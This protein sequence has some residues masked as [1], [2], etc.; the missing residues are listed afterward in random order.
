M[1][2]GMKSV[3]RCLWVL[4]VI[5]GFAATDAR[6][7]NSYSIGIEGFRDSYKEY[8][9]DAVA[10]VDPHVDVHTD[11]G[12]VTANYQ[13]SANGYFTAVDGRYSQGNSNYKSLSGVAN[14]IPDK[15]GEARLRF[16]ESIVVWHGIVMPY[17]GLGA[18]LFYDKFKEAGPGGYD[19]HIA[20]LYA[21][22][23][24]TYQFNWRGWMFRPNVEIDP[25]FWG[26]VTSKLGE[27]PGYGDVTNAQHGGVGLRGEFMAGQQY[28]SFG[29][30]VG[31]F[32]RYWHVD[33]SDIAPLPGAPGVGVVEPKNA[34][35]QAG[36]A[37]RVNF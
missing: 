18:R 28:K 24:A 8:F 34:R 4:C 23:G 30:E 6:A 10:G 1:G 13:H 5:G 20:Q 36:G 17:I 12:S 37:L 35:L 15:E 19:R 7:D 26:R 31:P 29:W 33:T 22:I 32:V 16:G 3:T 27:I 2:D 21:P 11:Y 14:H 9:I 25:L